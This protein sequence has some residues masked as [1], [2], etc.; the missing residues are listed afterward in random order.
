MSETLIG[1]A[2]LQARLRALQ[3]VSGRPLLQKM[4][5]I[6]VREARLAAPKKTG[7]LQNSIQPGAI[8]N[9]QAEIIAHA[10]YAGDVEFGTRPHEITPN[11]K[12]ALAFASQGITTQRF[13]GGA[14]LKFQLSGL[15][16]AASQRRYGNAAFVVVK[17]VHHPGTR[18]NPFMA[19]GLRKAVAASGGLAEII[20]KAWNE[21]RAA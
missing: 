15:L 1:G 18:A 11:A 21:G 13:G 14:I 12:K 10:N 16:T 4:V 7:D 17:S 2:Q 20:V 8:S 9:T 6:V 3:G 19:T 5:P